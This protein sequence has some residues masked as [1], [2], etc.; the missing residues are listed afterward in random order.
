MSTSYWNNN[1]KHSKTLLV[2]V[3]AAVKQTGNGPKVEKLL[4]AKR[5]YYNAMNNG[6]YRG[7]YASFGVGGQRFMDSYEL[8]D[9]CVRTQNPLASN[10]DTFPTFHGVEAKLDALIEAAHEEIFG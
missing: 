6:D 3:D 7:F 9:L 1:G 10:P 8:M 2:E 5:A 4:K